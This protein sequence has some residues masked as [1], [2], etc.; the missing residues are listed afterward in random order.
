MT[1]KKV[2]TDYFSLLKE[3]LEKHDLMDKP[4]QIYNCDE[5]G[6]PLEHKMPKTV[7]QKE[8]RRFYNYLLETKLKC[9]F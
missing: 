3:T 5:S 6:M 7:A 2:F 8:Q 4:S 9:P 1:S